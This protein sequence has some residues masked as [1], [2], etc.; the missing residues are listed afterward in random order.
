M[1]CIFFPLIYVELFLLTY[2]LNFRTEG[3]GT[4]NRG[5]SERQNLLQ[6]QPKPSDKRRAAGNP[7]IPTE[8]D[9]ITGVFLS[10]PASRAL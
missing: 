8:R 9:E 3:V 7:A 5:I 2:V 10:H 1:N 4:P 6:I